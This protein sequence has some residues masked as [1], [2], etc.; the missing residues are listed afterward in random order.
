M[1]KEELRLL[2]LELDNELLEAFPD[3]QPIRVLVVGGACL[4][5]AG[6]TER[7]TKDVDVII[8]DLFG[9]GE[10]SLVYNLTKTTRKVRTIIR[11]I[12]KKHGLR[13]D[14]AMFLNDD[15]AMF[16]LELGDLPPMRLLL[17]YR[18]LHLSIPE[19]LTYILACKLMAGRP[20]K[21]YSDIA[22]LRHLLGISTRTQAEQLVNRFFPD[23][24]LQGIYDLSKT[25]DQVFDQQK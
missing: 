3:P 14:D 21:D 11:R 25:L 16:L 1:N 7:P 4:L 12:G 23:P 10:A 18:K 2:L 13:G 22:T 9:T 5:F 24:V 19:D 8:T 15:C 17:E 6:V 20:A